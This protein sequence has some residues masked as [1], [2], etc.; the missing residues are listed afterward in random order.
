[1]FADARITYYKY[2]LIDFYRGRCDQHMLG[3][4]GCQ[5]EAAQP[6]VLKVQPHIR[7]SPLPSLS[8][9]QGE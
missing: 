9:Q 4:R 2:T 3:G 5:V 8:S 7:H 6:A 1:M